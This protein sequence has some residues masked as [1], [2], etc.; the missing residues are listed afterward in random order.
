ME[1]SGE[2]AMDGPEKLNDNLQQS[3]S[4]QSGTYIIDIVNSSSSRDT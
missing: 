3:G 4:T 1:S 2:S